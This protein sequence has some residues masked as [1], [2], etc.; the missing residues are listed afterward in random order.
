[1]LRRIQGMKPIATIVSTDFFF[2]ASPMNIQSRALRGWT[3]LICAGISMLC[4]SCVKRQSLVERYQ[5]IHKSMIGDPY[6]A[7]LEFFHERN[8]GYSF[9]LATIRP[10]KF[11]IYS[12][13]QLSFTTQEVYFDGRA[14]AIADLKG[15]LIVLQ[16]DEEKKVIQLSDDFDFDTA[17]KQISAILDELN[18]A[19]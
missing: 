10:S 13:T 17:E 6:H 15:Q 14:H 1:M 4:M 9:A 18:Q 8:S 3:L 7:M 5:H 12:K 16:D 2:T 11:D 19:E